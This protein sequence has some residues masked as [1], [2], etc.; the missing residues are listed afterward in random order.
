MVMGTRFSPRP[1]LFYPTTTKQTSLKLHSRLSGATSSNAS[2]VSLS[3]LASLLIFMAQ[4]SAVSMGIRQ[5]IL[6]KKGPSNISSP[7]TFSDR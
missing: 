1:P 4:F 5:L 3:N 6:T 2:D 7:N